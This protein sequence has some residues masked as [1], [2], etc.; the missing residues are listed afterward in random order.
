MSAA[1]PD[2]RQLFVGSEGAFGVVTE[3]T[4]R[5]RE[6]PADRHVEAWMVPPVLATGWRWSGGW[7]ARVGRPDM[8]RLSDP[9][10]TAASLALSGPSGWKRRG[11]DAY[12]G[13]RRA[14]GGCLLV[15]AWSGEGPR[16]AARRHA[17]VPVL[18]AARAVTL[19]GGAGQSWERGRYA[20]PYQRDVLIDRGYLVETLETATSWR[21]LPT[22][23]DR[24][25]PGASPRP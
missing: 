20:G 18:K 12:L 4:L 25:A 19:G 2:L 15:L 13:A 1:G 17:V 11:L 16:G 9:E 8:I 10:E 24:R 14:R 21:D 3:V 6:A 5:V 22:L 23:R 7:P